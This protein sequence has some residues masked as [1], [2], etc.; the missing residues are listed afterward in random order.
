M[1]WIKMSKYGQFAAAANAEEGAARAAELAGS[2]PSIMASS[3]GWTPACCCPS[4]PEALTLVC[5]LPILQIGVTHASTSW[6]LICL[7]SA[8]HCPWMFLHALSLSKLGCATLPS[9]PGTTMTI[10]LR[11]L[12]ALR[13]LRRR[14]SGV[15]LAHLLIAVQLQAGGHL[16]VL[17]VAVAVQ[18][19]GHPLVLLADARQA[20]FGRLLQHARHTR[21]MS[22][23]FELKAY[24]ALAMSCN[25]RQCIHLL[26][27]EQGIRGSAMATLIPQER[28]SKSR[29]IFSTPCK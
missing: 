11:R 26:K 28:Q 6:H 17:V 7:P 15:P 5:V 19:D 27:T 24:R 12:T 10:S 2:A 22:P 4:Y 3:V 14:R 8:T 23:P 18:Q 9:L 16:G 20:S 1:C 13:R 25:V 21:E 29:V